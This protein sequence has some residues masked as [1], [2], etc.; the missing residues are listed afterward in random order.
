MTKKAPKVEPPRRV[1][2]VANMGQERAITAAEKAVEVLEA[3]KDVEVLV[4]DRLARRLGRKKG[5]AQSK[6][7]VDMMVIAGGDGT[8]LH[9]LHMTNAPVLSINTGV[10]GFLAELHVEEIDA[11]IKR[12]L[13]GEYIL[14][15]RMRLKSTVNGRRQLDATNEVVVHT[16]AVS[17][18]MTLELAI[19]GNYVDTVRADGLIVATPTGS[20]SYALS[21]GGPIVD[22]RVRATVL[23]PIAPFNLHS[24]PMVV[25]ASS[26]TQIS[27]TE[28]HYP[29]LVVIDGQHEVHFRQRTTVEI[30]VSDSPAYFVRMGDGFYEKLRRKF[31]AVYPCDTSEDQ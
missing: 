29:G 15:E 10:V 26:V 24:R 31:I 8:I 22:P 30:T 20:T 16:A 2:V 25:P 9:G 13:N 18:M 1:G 17:K 23:S 6:L 14:D 19:D 7:D 28:Q 21:S 5:V 11:G 12:V 27:T 4:E 3:S